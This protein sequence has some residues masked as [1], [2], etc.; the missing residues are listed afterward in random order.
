MYA[1]DEKVS[2]YLTY[3]KFDSFKGKSHMGTIDYLNE[4]ERLYGKN[5]RYE[6][7]L[8]SAVLT[9]QVL[10]SSNLSNEKQ[11][12]RATIFELTSQLIN[13]VSWKSWNQIGASIHIEIK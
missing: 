6:M 3:E 8:P 12:A 1:K 13:R 10:R 4:F 11:L 2:V 9:Y 5:Q 7:T